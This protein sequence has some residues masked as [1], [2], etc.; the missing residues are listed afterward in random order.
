MS[1]EAGSTRVDSGT[2]SGAEVGADVLTGLA[3]LTLC[4]CG[5]SLVERSMLR[6]GTIS[7]EG[8]SLL[9]IVESA[10][11]ASDS[12]EQPANPTVMIVTAIAPAISRE[13]KE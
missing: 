3:E 13:P 1:A 8:M 7:T 4:L 10:R 12:L 6:V 11:S 5:G 9:V 2:D